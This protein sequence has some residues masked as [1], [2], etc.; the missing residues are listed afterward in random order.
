MIYTSKRRKFK[1]FVKTRN[2]S[3]YFIFLVL[4]VTII[5]CVF[6]GISKS[7]KNKTTEP[8]E[9]VTIADSNTESNTVV[10]TS[11]KGKFKICINIGNY[12]VSVYDWNDSKDEYNAT[13]IKYMPAAV[14]IKLTE[15][16]YSF[17]KEDLNKSNWFTT[18]SGE[19]YRYYTAFSDEIIFHT[20][21]YKEHNDKN[22]LDVISYNN[23][24]Q[25]MNAPGITLL[26]SDAKWIYEN[27]SYSSE[28]YV[29]NDPDEAINENITPIIPVPDG[30]TWDPTDTSSGSTF[31]QNKVGTIKCIYDYVNINYNGNVDFVKTF[32]KAY[33]EYGNDISSYV[34]TT[35]TGTFDTVESLEMTFYVADIYGNIISDSIIVNVVP[36]EE[37]SESDTESEN[38]TEEESASETETTKSSEEITVAPTEENTT[39]ANAEIPTEVVTEPTTE[40]S[41][42]A[43]T[44]ATTEDIT[45]PTTEGETNEATETTSIDSTEDSIS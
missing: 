17:V 24:G 40:L 10:D 41:T 38:E 1:D 15:G 5:A 3:Y 7:D 32:V 12:Q 13:A 45:E 16:T 42:E 30:L 23:I 36:T 4:F 9:E 34:F 6:I 35:L 37:A 21:R 29:Y 43:P 31:C 25:S 33:D 44:E 8:T 39:A 26:C 18:N 14:N 27:C 22:S 20:A 28:V 2:W 19:I 11:E